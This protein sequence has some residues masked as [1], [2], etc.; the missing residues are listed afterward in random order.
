MSYHCVSNL[1]QGPGIFHGSLKYTS[2][3]SDG[4]IDASQLLPYPQLSSPPD[5]SPTQIDPPV[6]PEVS[7]SIGLT[8]FHFILLYHDRVIAVGNLDERVTYE[9]LLP[10]VCSLNYVYLGQI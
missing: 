5:D 2:A 7:L 4:L 9:E 6:V 8:E 1:C 3:P 10:L